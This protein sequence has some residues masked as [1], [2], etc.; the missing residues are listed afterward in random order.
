MKLAS[1]LTA[2]AV[3]VALSQAALAAAPA[4]P[5]PKMGAAD[6][7]TSLE[8]QFADAKAANP[9]AAKLAAAQ[10]LADAGT[11]LCT[12]K[13]YSSGERKLTAA[14]ADLGVKPKT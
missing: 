1:L 7:C 14:L 10:K 9:K 2:S 8:K 11:K 12:E 3:V 6:R 5:Q 4:T 13:K